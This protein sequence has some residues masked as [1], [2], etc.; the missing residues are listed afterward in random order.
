SPAGPPTI[1]SI[2][3]TSGNAGTTVS[4]VL[5]GSGLTGATAVTFSGAGVTATLGRGA[6]TFLLLTITISSSAATGTRTVT[7]TAGG[8]TSAVFNSFTVNP[9]TP[10]I[11]GIS[12]TSADPGT[13]LNA[14]IYGKN[15][16]G[17]TSILIGG[18]GVTATIN[19]GGTST[20]LPVTITVAA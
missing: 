14:V 4:A 8:Q 2:S 17:V 18:S 9:I 15:L 11:T 1:T 19:P 3:P 13:T 16:T 10:E 5:F 7:V 12:V 6:D 20:T